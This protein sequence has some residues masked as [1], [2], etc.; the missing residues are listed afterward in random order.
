[1]S[2]E[3]TGYTIA[4]KDSINRN[5]FGFIF[6]SDNVQHGGKLINNITVYKARTLATN[7]D[8]VFEPMYKTVATTYI[9]RVLRFITTD[10]KED[11]IKDFFSN[12]PTS[13]KN[14]WLSNQDCV[15]SILQPGDDISVNIEGDNC[16]L[17]INFNGDVKNLTLE[18]TKN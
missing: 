4:T 3:I 15:N 14:K 10:F 2:K 8:G 16:H 7:E 5:N 11:K 6:S 12:K 13:Q 17:H 1:M 9:E 18:I